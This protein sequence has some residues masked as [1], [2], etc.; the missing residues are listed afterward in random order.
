MA[1]ANYSVTIK[2]SSKELSAKDR[3]RLKDTSDAIKLDEATETEALI[4]KP[5]NY[6]ILDVH[7]EKSENKD[8]SLYL[9]EDEQGNKFVTSSESFFNA[10]MDIYTE[11]EEE[12]EDYEIK[13]YR[14]P[15]KNYK[16]KSFIT[17]SIL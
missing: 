6:V 10:F 14:L 11:M 7:N 1:N 17:C 16:G 4:I 9:I 13:I 15:S 12:T 5:T 2:E 3:I 8:Y